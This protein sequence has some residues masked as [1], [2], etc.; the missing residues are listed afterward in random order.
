M[1]AVPAKP[2]WRRLIAA[3]RAAS[4][5]MLRLWALEDGLKRNAMTPGRK[6]CSS[7]VSIHRAIL[8]RTIL[9]AG[10]ENCSGVI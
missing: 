1:E 9:V 2:G 5:N 10:F 3:L 7:S 6:F 8:D 4:K